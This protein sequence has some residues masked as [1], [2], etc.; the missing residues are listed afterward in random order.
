ML[1]FLA[2]ETNAGILSGTIVFIKDTNKP[3]DGELATSGPFQP[4]QNID[5]L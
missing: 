4:V 1:T 5:L 2:T 3:Y